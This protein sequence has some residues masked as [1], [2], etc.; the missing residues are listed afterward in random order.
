MKPSAGAWDATL[1]VFVYRKNCDGSL[2]WI[3]AADN[4]R[5]VKALIESH[6]KQSSDEFLIRSLNSRELMRAALGVEH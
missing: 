1:P 3:G 6:S 2:V 4:K 5:A